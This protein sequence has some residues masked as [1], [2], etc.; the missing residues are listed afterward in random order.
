MSLILLQYAESHH[1]QIQ[2]VFTNCNST[3]YLFILDGN[4]NHDEEDSGACKRNWLHVIFKTYSM[5][6][7]FEYV[8]IWHQNVTQARINLTCGWG[9][10][11]NIEFIMY[12][13]AMVMLMSWKFILC[14][15]QCL[16]L[17]LAFKWVHES[18]KTMLNDSVALLTNKPNK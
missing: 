14:K 18:I 3:A 8:I 12:A 10:Y 9:N 2:C 4:G 17:R 7:M 6:S 1:R 13:M 5:C 11:L 16:D 15:F